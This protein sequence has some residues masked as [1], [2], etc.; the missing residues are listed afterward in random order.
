MSVTTAS[1]INFCQASKHKKKRLTKDGGKVF[2][3][4]IIV[5]SSLEKIE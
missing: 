1:K 2:K 3:A 5:A 4:S